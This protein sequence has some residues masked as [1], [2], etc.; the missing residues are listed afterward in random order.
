L[1]I[2]KIDVDALNQKVTNCAKK[3]R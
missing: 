3:H 2:F 1:S